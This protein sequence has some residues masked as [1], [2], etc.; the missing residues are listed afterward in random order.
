[1]YKLERK[2]KALA[3]GKKKKTRHTPAGLGSRT[4]SKPASRHALQ[5]VEAEAPS[6]SMQ[7]CLWH[8]QW[9]QA[10]FTLE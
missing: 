1:M 8:R 3:T 9:S 5:V 2:G 4:H 10:V 7:H 6:G